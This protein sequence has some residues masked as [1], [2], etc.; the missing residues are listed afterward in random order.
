M[1]FN[2]RTVCKQITSKIESLGQMDYTRKTLRTSFHP[3]QNTAVTACLNCFFI[4][5]I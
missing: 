3:T 4:Y 5:N 2:R 1:N